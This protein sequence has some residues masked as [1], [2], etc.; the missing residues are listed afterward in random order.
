MRPERRDRRNDWKMRETKKINK[1]RRP[2]KK[3]HE[4]SRTLSHKFLY[5]R[6]PQDRE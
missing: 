3:A 2:N 1:E 6:I 5:V 4:Y